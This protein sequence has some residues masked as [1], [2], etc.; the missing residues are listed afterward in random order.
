MNN[1][2]NYVNYIASWTRGCNVISQFHIT[3]LITYIRRERKKRYSQGRNLYCGY[4]PL[5]IW[6]FTWTDWKTSKEK[7]TPVLVCTDRRE[8]SGCGTFFDPSEYDLT[9]RHKDLVMSK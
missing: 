4:S 6:P 5:E 3:S 8:S 9:P 2:S 1:Y 7:A